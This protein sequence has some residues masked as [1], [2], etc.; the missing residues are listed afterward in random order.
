MQLHVNINRKKKKN[1]ILVG[2]CVVLGTGCI[3][4]RFII[5][6]HVS[7][8]AWNICTPYES[9]LTSIGAFIL[10]ILKYLL[11]FWRC[12][13]KKKSRKYFYLFGWYLWRFEI[14]FRLSE[15][16]K[17]YGTFPKKKGH[18]CCTR[19]RFLSRMVGKFSTSVW[20]IKMKQ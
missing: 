14:I 3:R 6:Q 16:Q 7:T 9:C 2:W 20:Q 11:Q 13:K 18:C 4:D 8:L 12:E 15:K 10:I 19:V 1:K 5:S 17:N